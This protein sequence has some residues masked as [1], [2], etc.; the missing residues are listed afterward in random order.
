[1]PRLVIIYAIINRNIFIFFNM[2]YIFCVFEER[3]CESANLENSLTCNLIMRDVNLEK[4]KNV[5]RAALR[6]EFITQFI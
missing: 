1:M 2:K 6:I 4:E 3:K 5:R